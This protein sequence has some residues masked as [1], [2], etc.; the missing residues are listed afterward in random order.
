MIKHVKR[1]WCNNLQRLIY[2]NLIQ[3]QIK[4]VITKSDNSKK[5]YDI[6]YQ[7]YMISTLSL[8]DLLV[9]IIKNANE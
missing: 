2:T 7:L 8:I 5:I 9:Y 6:H 4:I 3:N 1:Y